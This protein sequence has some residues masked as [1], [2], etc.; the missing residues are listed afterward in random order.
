MAAEVVVLGSINVD[1]IVSAERLPVAGETVAGKDIEFQLGGKGANQ[2]VG[3]ARAGAATRFLGCIGEDE[4]GAAMLGQL[5][6]FGVDVAAVRQVPGRTGFAIVATCPRDNQI[7]VVPGANSHVDEALADNA[8]VAAGDACLAQRETPVAASRRLFSAARAVGATTLLN[9][10]PADEGVHALLPL[11]DILI[12][13]EG[14]CRLLASFPEADPAND[15]DLITVRRRLGLGQNQVL[16]ATLGEAGVAIAA[17]DCVRRIP[18]ESVAVLDTTGA[19]DCFCGYLAAGLAQGIS[20]ESAALRANIAAS[21]AVQSRGAACSVPD[22][23]AVTAI[24]G[25]RWRTNGRE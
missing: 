10:A 2:A 22:I 13:N 6:G 21:L 15:A 7:I 24:L 16:I 9:A 20:L 17:A 8:R 11:V 12:A 18:G 14:E 1:L 4:N 5:R 23:A 3:A 19:G 25:A